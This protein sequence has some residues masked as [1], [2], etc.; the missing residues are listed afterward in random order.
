MPESSL[1]FHKH[2]KRYVAR[3]NVPGV[4]YRQDNSVAARFTETM[5]VVRDDKPE[6]NVTDVTRYEKTNADRPRELYL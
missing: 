5:E 3:L 4:A 2:H 6:K 1:D